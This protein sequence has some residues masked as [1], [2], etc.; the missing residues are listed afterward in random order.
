MP[1]FAFVT[2]CPAVLLGLG[3]LMGGLW[4]WAGF[5]FMAGL[6]IVIDQMVPM[7]NT[8]LSDGAEFPAGDVVLVAV[9]VAHLAM[10]PAAVWAIAGSSDLTGIERAALFVGCGAWMGQVAHPA[11]HELIHRGQRGLYRLGVAIYVTMLFGHH[12]SAHRLVH[13][14]RVAT[15]DDPNS[16]PAGMSFWRFA[17]R[18]WA[19][20]FQTGMVAETALRA[21][22]GKRG[23]H[24]YAIY[25]GGAAASLGFGGAIAGWAGA[26]V[27]LGLAAHA[28][29]QL[30]LADYVQHYGLQRGIGRDGRV[31]PVSARH[32]WNSPHW[33]S[34]ALMLNAPRHSDHHAH[35]S[36][37]YP[38]LTLPE[39]APILPWPLPL[40]CAIALWPRMWRRRMKPLLA[41]WA[42]DQVLE[43]A[44]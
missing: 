15:A 21:R 31:E 8:P 10:L 24:P 37:P 16:A 32:S 39:D 6:S 43:R 5:L 1:I 41:E 4:L 44:G 17:P 23:V 33:F 26:L 28:Q 25:L 42:K 40:A 19:G 30:L 13:H 34:S 22:G 3:L 7:V 27:W 11:A 18:A 29:M 9:A 35:P 36:R 12:A 38:A 14:A 20:S 2:L